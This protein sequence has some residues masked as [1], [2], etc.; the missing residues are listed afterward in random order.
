MEEEGSSRT[1]QPHQGWLATGN[2]KGVV[3]IT[4]TSSKPDDPDEPVR[5]N[6]YLR[7]HRSEVSRSHVK[8]LLNAETFVNCISFFQNKFIFNVFFFENSFFN[9]FQ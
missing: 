7:G 2:S 3:G 5:T 4:F 1:A 9:K 8:D 6:F